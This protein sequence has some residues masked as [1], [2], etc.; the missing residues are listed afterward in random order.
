M[1]DTGLILPSEYCTDDPGLAANL[2][3]RVAVSGELSGLLG[4][5]KF[6]GCMFCKPYTFI[7]SSSSFSSTFPIKPCGLFP[8]E[9]IWNYGSYKQ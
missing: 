7:S 9:L 1:Y 6:K 8:L 3:S 4:G 5:H 2:F